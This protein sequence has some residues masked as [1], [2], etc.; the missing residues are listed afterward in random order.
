MAGGLAL[1]TPIPAR[2]LGPMSASTRTLA[3]DQG[4]H[5]NIATLGSLDGE[6]KGI[7][8]PLYLNRL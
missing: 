5:E 8:H 1:P 6:G 7:D 3:G 4:L 2:S